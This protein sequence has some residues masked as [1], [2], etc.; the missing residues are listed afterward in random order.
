MRSTPTTC[1]RA[2][3]RPARPGDERASVL[4]NLAEVDDPP[5]S[6]PVYY[7]ALSEAEDGALRA[8][9][10]LRL[11]DAMGWGDGLEPR[12]HHGELAVVEASRSSDPVAMCRA[13]GTYGLALFYGG[14][15]I[16]TATMA[17]AMAIE[18]SLPDWPIHEGPTYQFA[19]QLVWSAQT[20]PGHA[21]FRELEAAARHRHD[22]LAELDAMFHL[23]LA[24][25]RAGEWPEAER[26]AASG[27]EIAA[28]F[29]DIPGP[30]RFPSAIIAAHQGRVA[31]ARAQA[32]T[33]FARGEATG[34]RIAQSG[35]SWVLGFVDL[36]LGDAPAA[37][38]HLRRAYEIRDAFML[39]PAQRIE[40]GDLIEALIAIGEL[41]EADSVLAIWQPRAEAVDR[42]WSL[43]IL[44]RCRALLVAARGDVPSALQLFDVALAEHVRAGD[45]FQHARTLLALGRTQRRAKQRA[46]ARATLGESLVRFEHLGAALWADQSRA[47]IARIGGRVRAGN[48]LTE[49]ERRIADL[50]A[51][52][53]SNREVATALYI[54]ERSVEAAL[55]RIYRKLGVGSRAALVRLRVSKPEVST[56][57]ARGNPAT[58]VCGQAQGVWA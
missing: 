51:E 54:T 1:C 56:F 9:I 35:H 44:A 7:E 31:D 47:E 34:V 37:V 11:A 26:V 17:Q 42:S 36:S 39:E 43:A 52:G 29:G 50:V 25:W 20:G 18:R 12:L 19:A 53:R 14:R 22:A 55:T 45:P 23:S 5:A 40:L 8:R 58:V 46:A 28:Q 30:A 4:L 27:L 24:A 57:G 6:I 38:V 21:L 48:E 49:A 3:W 10:H 13:L 2:R 15:G 32:E 33:A 16:A 41:D